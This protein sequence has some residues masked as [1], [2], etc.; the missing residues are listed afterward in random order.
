MDTKKFESFDNQGA[1]IATVSVEH[2]WGHFYVIKHSR[3]E[4][5]VPKEIW[6]SLFK[7][8]KEEAVKYKAEVIGIR[9]RSDFHLDL[10]REILSELNFSKI[11]GRIEY[12]TEVSK[13][14]SFNNN[15][16]TWKTASEL[17]WDE[18]QIAEFTKEIIVGALDIEPDEKAEDFIQD[19][20]NHPEFTYGK[21][22]I[23]IGF[24]EHRAV[25]LVVAQVEKKSG[26]SRLSYMGLI[27][28][29]RN[30][31]L[32]KWV[33]RHGFEMIKSQ[34][35]TLYHGGTHINN[36]SMRKLFEQHGCQ[37]F[38][39]LEEWTFKT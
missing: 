18:K 19:W 33:H 38:C 12:K 3:P 25:A 32:G 31:G 37:F 7:Q 6:L 30:K 34:G 35:G 13:L 14:P 8:A 20:M 36:V 28:D 5:A 21:E 15:A 10:F 2:L 17:N 1:V 23:A 9:L 39:E 16:L 24:R 29:F 26:W 11:A 4:V 27:P 22:C